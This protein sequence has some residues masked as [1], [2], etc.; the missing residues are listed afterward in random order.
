MWS[1][2]VK[3]PIVVGGEIPSALFRGLFLHLAGVV[4]VI[5]GKCVNTS[6]SHFGLESIWLSFL[7]SRSLFWLQRK[8]LPSHRL[9]P[10]EVLFSQEGSSW[11]LSQLK[12]IF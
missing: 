5:L 8:G 10:N 7:L 2:V 3:S 4:L 11:L 12:E 6:L 1:T 9:R